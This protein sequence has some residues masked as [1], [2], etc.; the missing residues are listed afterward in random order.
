MEFCPRCGAPLEDGICPV[1]AEREFVELLDPSF[2][3]LE[4]K[5]NSAVLRRL[6]EMLS[7]LEE[8]EDFLENYLTV[9]NI[10][11]SAE[12]NDI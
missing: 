11:S 7:E 1:C 4:K 5:A 12:N 10:S 6:D 3:R 9:K 2:A 8:L